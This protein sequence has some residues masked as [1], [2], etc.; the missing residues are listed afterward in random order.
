MQ[1]PERNIVVVDD[2]AG[3]NQAIER[4]LSAAGLRVLTFPSGEALLEGGAAGT[5]ACLVFDIHLPGLSGFE[6]HERL[7]RGGT[8]AYGDPASL[9]QARVAGAAGYFTKPFSGPAFLEAIANAVRPRA[10]IGH[11]TSDP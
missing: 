4:L 11:L 6:L 7:R 10:K 8:T 9:A 1:E 3:M 2:D 5:A